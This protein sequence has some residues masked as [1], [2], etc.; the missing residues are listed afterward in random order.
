MKLV[1]ECQM[2]RGQPE[3]IFFVGWN[4]IYSE[5]HEDLFRES[6]QI[7]YKSF[8]DRSISYANEKGVIYSHTLSEWS[9][10]VQARPDETKPDQIPANSCNVS[11]YSHLFSEGSR[12][13]QVKTFPLESSSILRA[14]LSRTC[15]LVWILIFQVVNL[16]LTF[17]PSWEMSSSSGIPSFPSVISS[18]ILSEISLCT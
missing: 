17:F 6:M 1:S 16:F 11:I 9:G 14:D 13:G 18:V 7:H 5:V 2:H 8:Q 4:H 10:P 3:N 12:P 15:I